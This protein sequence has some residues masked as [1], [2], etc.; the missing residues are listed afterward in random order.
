M[1]CVLQLRTILDSH[2]TKPLW[3]RATSQANAASTRAKY[4]PR[5]FGTCRSR[6]EGE[7]GWPREIPWSGRRGQEDR[8]R[9]RSMDKLLLFL[10]VKDVQTV[11]GSRREIGRIVFGILAGIIAQNDL[12]ISQVETTFGFVPGAER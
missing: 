10:Q 4:E 11:L 12:A 8:A 7:R 5:D 3:L 2:P 6:D 1:E 9:A